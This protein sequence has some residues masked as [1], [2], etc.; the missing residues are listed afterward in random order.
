[1]GHDLSWSVQAV[2][3]PLATREALR[4][5]VTFRRWILMV[6]IAV[7]MLGFVLFAESYWMSFY[8][9]FGGEA[10]PIFIGMIV[11]APYYAALT[12]AFMLGIRPV[13]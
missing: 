3:W 4:S 2:L 9:A 1:M 8:A 11:A 6:V 13:D 10:L 7:T 5:R 12:T